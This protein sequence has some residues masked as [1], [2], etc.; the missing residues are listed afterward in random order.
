MRFKS[1]D[2]LLEW[3]EVI[4]VFALIAWIEAGENW[5]RLL[6]GIRSI[7][8]CLWELWMIIY[9][10][11]GYLVFWA[12]RDLLE[13]LG[14]KKSRGWGHNAPAHPDMAG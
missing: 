14:P 4:F 8:M 1:I 7:R 11:A 13:Q 3:F 2:V 6:V 9:H 5:H 12:G 10:L